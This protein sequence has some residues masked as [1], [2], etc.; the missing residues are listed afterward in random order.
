MLGMVNKL[1]E[2]ERNNVAYNNKVFLLSRSRVRSSTYK[3]ANINLWSVLLKE[4]AF[5]EALI[6][7]SQYLNA[8]EKEIL[9]ADLLTRLYHD[10]QQM[11]HY[12]LQTKGIQ[13]NQLFS[14]PQIP[15]AR[16]K[17]SPFRDQYT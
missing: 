16:W 17:C 12:V 6:E 4:E 1:N 2:M 13:A 8:L 10:F 3:P 5:D 9:N 15:R 7:V 11:M 14:D